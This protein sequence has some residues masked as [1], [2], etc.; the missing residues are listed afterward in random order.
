[1]YNQYNVQ[2]IQCLYEKSK[3]T[4]ATFLKAFYFDRNTIYCLTFCKKKN[5]KDLN[6]YISVYK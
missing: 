4:F 1:M 2:S 6:L 3:T 5:P